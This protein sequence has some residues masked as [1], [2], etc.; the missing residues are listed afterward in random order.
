MASRNARAP[1]LH[2]LRSCRGN[3]ELRAVSARRGHEADGGHGPKWGSQ[4]VG[5]Q[6]E[7]ESEA[8]PGVSVGKGGRCLKFGRR[9]DRKTGLEVKLYVL[10][11]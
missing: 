2:Q 3:A 8:S 7:P 10:F 9:A 4:V 1:I 11:N 5:W 6:E